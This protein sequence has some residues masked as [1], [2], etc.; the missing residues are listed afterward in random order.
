MLV[1]CFEFGFALY[2]LMVLVGN[3]VGLL[4]FGYC[5]K[6][7]ICLDVLV[8][9]KFDCVCFRGES[10][11]GWFVFCCFVWFWVS[12]NNVVCFLIVF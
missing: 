3:V 11:C 1:A 9:F 6:L 5:Y 8:C 4:L 12:V 2:S 10:V 7:F